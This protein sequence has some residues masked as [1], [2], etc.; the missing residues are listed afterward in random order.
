MASTPKRRK[1]SLTLAEQRQLARERV[2]GHKNFASDQNKRVK[3]RDDDIR[4]GI[5]KRV[6]RH[7]LPPSPDANDILSIT[8]GD[9]EAGRSKAYTPEQIR[10]FAHNIQQASDSLREGIRPQDVI[11]RSLP[12]PD[13]HNANQQIFLAVPFARK[14]DTVRYVTN[15]GPKSKHH[16]HY[17]SVQFLGWRAMLTG[18]REKGTASVRNHIAGGKIK[19]SCDCERHRYFYNYMATLGKYGI[20]TPETRFPHIRNPELTGIACK[21]VL[22]VMHTI[23]A[24]AGV[25]YL[26]NELRKDRAKEDQKERSEMAKRKAMNETIE[27]QHQTADHQR[28]RILPETERPGYQARLQREAQKAAERE[29]KRIA[30]RDTRQQSEKARLDRLNAALAAGLLTREDYDRYKRQTS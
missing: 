27:R 6:T 3:E 26:L 13:R 12:E 17:V 15:A 9:D 21:H 22:R 10:A 16:R 1:V 4:D 18:S 7:E 19:F 28:N 25:Q 11:N 14:G 2:Q 20:G 23:L 24:G 5:A 29:A 8:L 30:A